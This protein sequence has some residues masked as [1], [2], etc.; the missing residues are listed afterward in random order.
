[1]IATYIRVAKTFWKLFLGERVQV[2]RHYALGGAS[3]TAVLQLMGEGCDEKWKEDLCCEICV[4]G[5]VLWIS[6][7]GSVLLVMFEEWDEKAEDFREFRVV[8]ANMESEAME[9]K[10]R[11][12]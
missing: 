12:M 8:S 2:G 3:S 7:V 10:T 11:L 9:G 6:V 5:S 4:V 1:M